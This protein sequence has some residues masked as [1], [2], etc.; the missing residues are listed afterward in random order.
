MRKIHREALFRMKEIKKDRSLAE[1][2][3]KHEDHLIE[4]FEKT[5][6]KY[7]SKEIAF[8]EN[9]LKFNEGVIDKQLEQAIIIL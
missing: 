5:W 4:A 1:S 8:R 3:Q 2:R 6:N 9:K 7:M